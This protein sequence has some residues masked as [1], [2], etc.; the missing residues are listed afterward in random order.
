MESQAMPSDG[1]KDKVNIGRSS[2]SSEG[3]GCC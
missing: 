3:G 1:P 2:K